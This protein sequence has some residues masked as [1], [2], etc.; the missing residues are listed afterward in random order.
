VAYRV[1][2]WFGWTVLVSLLPFAA[3]AV[4]IW[5][6]LQHPPALDPLV[7]SGQLLVT[8]VALLAG[9]IRELSG[10]NTLSRSKARDALHLSSLIFVVLL[11]VSYGFIMGEVV[12]N[13]PLPDETRSSIVTLSIASL[14]ISII[15]G[16]ISMAIS[17]PS[18]GSRP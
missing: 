13:R 3:V 17:H 18:T 6:S 4:V 7:G 1:I 10:M 15:V 5:L 14:G 9:A 2:R 11:S 8:C 16:S 12:A